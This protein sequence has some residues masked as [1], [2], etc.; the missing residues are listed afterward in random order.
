MQA[1]AR[2]TRERIIAQAKRAFAERGFEATNLT[3][4]I[5]TPAGVSVGSFYHQ[6][7]NKR[8]VLLEIFEHAIRVRHEHIKDR[9]RNSTP[10]TFE[11][12]LRNVLDALLDDVDAQHEVWL[13]QWREFE[14]PDPEIRSRALIGIDEWIEIALQIM[15]PW[16]SRDHPAAH[17]AARQVVL[18]GFG[19]AREYTRTD[20]VDRLVRR[21]RLL[22]TAVAFAGAGLERLLGPT[23]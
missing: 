2:R 9:V 7:S 17:D 15:A 19:V 16:Y 1:R 8:E 5:L 14:S 3:E 13:I 11:E 23:S 18:I 22:S 20:E 10:S 6:F 4:H 21:D 12:A